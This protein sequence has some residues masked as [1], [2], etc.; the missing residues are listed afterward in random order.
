LV[1][2]FSSAPYSQTPFVPPV[3]SRNQVSHPYRATGKIVVLHI[4][5]FVFRL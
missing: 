5:I 1:Q 3:N 4:L 2:I